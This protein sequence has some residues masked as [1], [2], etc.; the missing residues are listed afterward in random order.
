MEEL[1]SNVNDVV[2][3]TSHLKKKFSLILVI[4]TEFVGLLIGKVYK[5]RCIILIHRFMCVCISWVLH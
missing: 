2:D 3:N 5:L 1:V 4:P